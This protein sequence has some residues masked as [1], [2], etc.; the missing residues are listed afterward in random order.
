[1]DICTQK[2][3]TAEMCSGKQLDKF[4]IREKEK[5]KKRLHTDT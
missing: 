2:V 4:Q 5:E 1:M 3:T